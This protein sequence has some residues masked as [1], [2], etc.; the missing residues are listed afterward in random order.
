MPAKLS[1]SIII[2]TVNRADSLDRTLTSLNQLRYDHFEVLVVNGPSSDHTAQVIARYA[3]KLRAY[4]TDQA[5]IS[6]SRNIGL[7]HARGDIAIFIDDDAVPE[8]DWLEALLQ[9]YADPNVATVGGFIRDAFGFDY[10]AR[11]TVCDRFGDA[12]QF[13]GADEF[14]LDGESFLSLTGTNFSARREALLAIGGFDEEYIWFLDETDVNL[15]MHDRGLKFA[16]AAGAE[17][18]HKYEAGLTRTRSAAP[19]TM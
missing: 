19:R 4:Q 13:A 10:Q 6:V 2:V 14:T 1:A 3:H 9:P 7:A 8:P 5:N 17:I 16:V 11:Y 15:R 12:R 18:H